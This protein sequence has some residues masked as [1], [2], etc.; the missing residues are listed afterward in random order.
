MSKN[1]W[2]ILISTVIV[3]ISIAIVLLLILIP[4]VEVSTTT[5]EYE[6]ITKSD[7]TYTPTK[8]DIDTKLTEKYTVTTNKVSEGISEEH[9][10]PGNENPFT[11]NSYKAPGSSDDGK[12]GTT[13]INPYKELTPADK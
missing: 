4:Q 7:Y 6:A 13:T 5:G 1:T 8:E 3:I 9:Y 12:D 11:P 2:I 10:D